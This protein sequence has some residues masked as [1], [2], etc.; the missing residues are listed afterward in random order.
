MRKHID[1]SEEL[2]ES[3]KT[4]DIIAITMAA[5][6]AMGDPGAIELVD[7]DLKVYYTHFGDISEEALKKA[8]PFLGTLRV[9]FDKIDGIGNDWAGLY[10]GYGNYLFVRPD[11][12]EP[13]LDFIKDN[14]GDSK[15]PPAV[16]LYSHWYDALIDIKNR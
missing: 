6:G 16:E 14:Y 13:I 12:K 10:T 5:G 4:E 15:L 11:L 1:L 2:L 3:I 7:K 8:I 9:E